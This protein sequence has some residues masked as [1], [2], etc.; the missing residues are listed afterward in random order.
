MVEIWKDIV[1]YEGL[2]QVS[3]HGRV[4]SLPKRKGKGAGYIKG[5]SILRHSVNSRGYCNIILCKGGRTKTFAL[6]RLVA[7]HFIEN[8]LNLPEV[9]HKD[10]NTVNNHVSNLRWATR[11]ENNANRKV[12]FP[13]VCVET[14]EVYESAAEAGK[15]L[16]LHGTSIT[17]CCRNKPYHKTCGGYHWEYK[18][19]VACATSLLYAEKKG[20]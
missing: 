19:G 17:A 9:D 1:G 20:A 2:Y 14:G 16:G 6:H 8:T 13:V 5:E 15:E 7:E 4:K 11:V 10:R 3:N 18:E 12:G